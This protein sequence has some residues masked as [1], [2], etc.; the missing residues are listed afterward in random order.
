MFGIFHQDIA[1]S[2]DV[3]FLTL[4]FDQCFTDDFHRIDRAVRLMSGKINFAKRTFAD[5]RLKIEII[6][7]DSAKPT[8]DVTARWRSS[9]SLNLRHFFCFAQIHT[10]RVARL[11]QSS[12][13]CEGRKTGAAVRLNYRCRWFFTF[14]AIS[15]GRRL[16]PIVG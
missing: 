11:D 2:H 1:F 8:R 16:I 3:T 6:G 13:Q 7:F 9:S 14:I 10:H 4:P 15:F 12:N 5:T